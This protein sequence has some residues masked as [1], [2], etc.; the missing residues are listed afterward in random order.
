M[1]I[2]GENGGGRRMNERMEEG[3]RRGQRRGLMCPDLGI[4]ST[5]AEVWGSALT[6]P[7]PTSVGPMATVKKYDQTER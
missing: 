5:R 1:G 3:G 7:T 6:N 4:D 2:E